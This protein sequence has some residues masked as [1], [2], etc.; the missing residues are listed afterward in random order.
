M[1]GQSDTS[2]QLNWNIS[3]FPTSKLKTGRS[4]ERKNKY[5]AKRQKGK[6]VLALP[7]WILTYNNALCYIMAILFYIFILAC[8]Y[9][10]AIFAC[11]FVSCARFQQP[12]NRSAAKTS[13]SKK[14]RETGNGLGVPRVPPALNP[15]TTG[16][17]NQPS[18][19]VQLHNAISNVNIPAISIAK[20]IK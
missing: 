12:G 16:A 14:Q 13:C 7:S 5:F 17:P 18:P 9:Q 20:S 15:V 19:P 11:Y 1:W 10:S 4:R 3:L 8:R 6:E 2:E